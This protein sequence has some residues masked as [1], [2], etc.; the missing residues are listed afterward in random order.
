[1]D[2]ALFYRQAG[3]YAESLTYFSRIL[4]A[5][6]RNHKACYHMAAIFARQA[7]SDAA[8]QWLARAVALGFRDIGMLQEDQSW[9]PYRRHPGF[10]AV[11]NRLQEL[12][13]AGPA[14]E[15][16]GPSR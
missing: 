16:P 9:E 7:N 5:D 15:N 13:T 2:L 3:R 6:S 8:L 14:R 10:M 12:N 1:M 4:A 11:W